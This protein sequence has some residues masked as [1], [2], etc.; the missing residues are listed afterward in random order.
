MVSELSGVSPQRQ[1]AISSN[2]LVG[3]VERSVVQSAHITEPWFWLH[4]QVKKR[5]LS[6][7][8]DTSKYAWKDTKK[9]LHYMQDDVT[10]VFLQIDDNFCYE[11]FDI[12]VSDSTKDNQA[13]EQLHSLIQPAMQNGASLLDIAEIITL[14]NLSMIKSK[15]RDI[16]NNRMQQQQALQ[17]QEAQQQQQLVQMQNEVKEQELML[18]EAEMDLEKYKI[19]QDNATKITVAQLNAYRGTENMD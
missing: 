15:L 11:D 17:E 14:D 16:E 12:F 1:G 6:M 7:L 4:N 9:Y 5:V 2:E 10:R 8:L 13:I 18:K 3:N 19:D